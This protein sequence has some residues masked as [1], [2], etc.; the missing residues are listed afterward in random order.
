LA[1]GNR[2]ALLRLVGAHTLARFAGKIRFV[3]ARA[4]P[5]RAVRQSR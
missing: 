2:L 1:L 3:A 4:M 5:A